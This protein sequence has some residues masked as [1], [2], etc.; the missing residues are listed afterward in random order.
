MSHVDT[1]VQSASGPLP[2]DQ[3][4]AF[5]AGM[6]TV[7][8]F[9]ALLDRVLDEDMRSVLG[10]AKRQ[11]AAGSLRI[12]EVVDL[13]WRHHGI[14]PEIFHAIE[15]L[16]PDQ[17]PKVR[18]LARLSGVALYTPLDSRSAR[19]TL[20][21]QWQR[22]SYPHYI[23]RTIQAHAARSWIF[24][25]FG[26]SR[27]RSTPAFLYLAGEL[28]SGRTRVAY[29]YGRCYRYD[30]DAVV[31]LE[32]GGPRM[33]KEGIEWRPHGE[34]QRLKTQ[35]SNVAIE[36]GL[37]PQGEQAPP[38]GVVSPE[39]RD[40][41]LRELE[42]RFTETGA[43][44]LLVMDNVVDVA[45]ARGAAPRAGWFDVLV[46]CGKGGPSDAPVEA[47]VR[48]DRLSPQEAQ[49]LLLRGD[50]GA[51]TW[52]VRSEEA[53]L[54]IAHRL[55]FQP[56]AL[57]IVAGLLRYN[58][59][60]NILEWM[61][62]SG[63][64]GAVGGPGSSGAS[65]RARSVSLVTARAARG[66]LHPPPM[67]AEPPA[68]EATRHVITTVR[69]AHQLTGVAPSSAENDA[70][71]LVMRALAWVAAEEPIG[72]SFLQRLVEAMATASGATSVTPWRSAYLGLA[73]DHLARAGLV[74]M[75]DGNPCVHPLTQAAVQE[76]FG[77]AGLRDALIVL[78]AMV[79]CARDE[80]RF[81]EGQWSW[82]TDQEAEDP[83]FLHLLAGVWLLTRDDVKPRVR[84]AHL[85]LAW[86]VVRLL[87]RSGQLGEAAHLAE[88]VPMEAEDDEEPLPAARLLLEHAQSLLHGPDPRALARVAPRLEQARVILDRHRDRALPAN[89]A[90]ELDRLL[91]K[92]QYTLADLWN[93]QRR[94]DEARALLLDA[95]E[96]SGPTRRAGGLMHAHLYVKLA[97]T[98]KLMAR[99][100][101]PQAQALRNEALSNMRQALLAF[102]ELADSGAVDLR[103]NAEYAILLLGKALLDWEAFYVPYRLAGTPDRAPL[104]R[105]RE[106][107][108]LLEETRRAF[109][110]VVDAS[111]NFVSR[112]LRAEADRCIDLEQFGQAESKA[113]AAL[114]IER[115]LRDETPDLAVSLQILARALF[116]HA[117]HLS[118]RTPSDERVP[119]WLDEAEALL[120]EALQ[121][122][123]ASGATEG[124][125]R[126]VEFDR[127][128]VETLAGR[129]DGREE[130]H[131]RFDE[132]ARLWGPESIQAIYRQDWLKTPTPLVP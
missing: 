60:L 118:A 71:W 78:D 109:Q 86:R 129:V 97:S 83:C 125:T 106:N 121:H 130:L 57:S 105:V 50:D 124:E 20:D 48:L 117:V 39:L 51:S 126:L 44:C 119:A 98:Y 12:Q 32:G 116:L 113:R 13:L 28:G 18:Q 22:F 66:A 26:E 6:F 54:L 75:M 120:A 115:A 99:Q 123:E 91:I 111:H 107:L 101:G 84:A 96:R 132:I 88:S 72:H 46:I 53:A 27:P 70:A 128:F 56:L 25:F 103:K 2:V 14:G 63:R 9:D 89:L 11:V 1:V 17:R 92:S 82:R 64:E 110:Q 81:P 95:I 108:D 122:L 55:G 34:A 127:L 77:D 94:L 24:H 90:D 112:V 21:E 29:E 31:F 65:W 42:L 8:E 62:G 80:E 69:M 16:H 76:V 102:R 30:Y 7:E 74:W 49:R 52:S 114:A 10:A 19:R 104:A 87:K 67:A 61:G 45:Q 85:D 40:R 37:L 35:L 15:A 93:Q 43:R 3:L 4:G 33:V 41:V 36:W 131:R 23:E 68:L 100:G 5:V 58:R 38:D 59:P 79:A 47:T 73:L